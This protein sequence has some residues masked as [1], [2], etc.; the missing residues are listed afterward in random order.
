MADASDLTPPEAEVARICQELI[1]IDTSNFGDGSG[2]G[3]RE[4]ADYVVGLLREVGLEPDVY[5]SDPGGRRSPYGFLAPTGSGP[6]CASTGT[7][8][9]SRPRPPTGRS[10]PSRGRSG[11]A[12]SGA[13]GPST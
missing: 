5:E 7:S 9:S 2:P 3:E 12:A 13:A 8:T 10:T 4:A 11:T 6:R 1:R